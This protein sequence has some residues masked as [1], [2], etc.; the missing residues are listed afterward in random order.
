MLWSLRG[1]ATAVEWVHEWLRW[2]QF[3]V[4][5]M[6]WH[7][8][9]LEVIPIPVSLF[10]FLFCGGCWELF[11]ASVIN[12]SCMQLQIEFCAECSFE[13][14]ATLINATET[15]FKWIL[16][17]LAVRWPVHRKLFHC[18]HRLIV[19][20][21][22]IFWDSFVWHQAWVIMKLFFLSYYF[23]ST[24]TFFM[25]SVFFKITRTHRYTLYHAPEINGVKKMWWEVYAGQNYFLCHHGVPCIGLVWY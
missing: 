24:P 18:S 11:H 10:L 1:V 16:D 20:S 3:A 12:V 5:H 2:C 13:S 9:N 19:C 23:K 15:V 14:Y 21:L 17:C 25:R 7:R 22:C 6:T 8:C 4:S